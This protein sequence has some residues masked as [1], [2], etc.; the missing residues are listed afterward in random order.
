VPIAVL[1]LAAQRSFIE[2]MTQG[3]VKG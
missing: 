2:G 1:F 3:A